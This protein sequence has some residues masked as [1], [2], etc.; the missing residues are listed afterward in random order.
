[1]RCEV[2]ELQTAGTAPDHTPNEVLGETGSPRCFVTTHCPDH[3][4]RR[5]RCSCQPPVHGALQPDRHGH[6]PDV[7]ALADEIYDR[8]MTLSDLNIFHSQG[9]QLG[10]A[11]ATTKQDRYHGGIANAA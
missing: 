10:S 2:V 11:Q 7:I 3:S 9:G 6:S 8:P 5:N 1:M 4:S